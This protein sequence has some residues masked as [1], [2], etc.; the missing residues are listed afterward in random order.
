MSESVV[1]YR[2]AKA[3]IDLAIEQKVVKEVNDDMTFF[4][5][6]C[7]INKDFQA[8]MANPII[9]HSKKLN[10]LK[11]IFEKNVNSVTFSIFDVL[12]RKNRESLIY[13]ISVEFQKLYNELNKVQVATVTSVEP[14]TDTQKEEILK[15]VKDATG[16]SV[17]LSEEIDKSLIGGYVLRVGDVQ[18]DTSIR[19]S[20]NELKLAVA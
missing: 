13:P 19:K 16:R 20:L 1:A 11:E 6:V 18:Y 8:V 17:E 12:T 4:S 15:I 14:I 3:L 7:G 2:Y 9:R 10:I 5:D